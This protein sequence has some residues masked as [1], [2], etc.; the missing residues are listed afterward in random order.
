MKNVYLPCVATID[1][2]VATKYDEVNDCYFIVS[3]RFYGGAWVPAKDIAVL[4]D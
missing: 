3:A 2:A 1:N 4:K